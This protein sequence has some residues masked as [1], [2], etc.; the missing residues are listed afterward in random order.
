VV[1]RRMQKSSLLTDVATISRST[2]ERVREMGDFTAYYFVCVDAG[3]L[4]T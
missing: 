2:V 4:S 3:T 1:E